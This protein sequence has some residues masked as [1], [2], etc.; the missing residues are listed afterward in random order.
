MQIL[1]VGIP[2]QRLQ[3]SFALFDSCPMGLYFLLPCAVKLGFFFFPHQRII[4]VSPK[5]VMDRKTHHA[6]L[7]V[8]KSR[9]AV[10][11]L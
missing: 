6:P 9:E 8:R 7:H 2:N 5:A 1:N 4:L 10:G 11:V 3:T